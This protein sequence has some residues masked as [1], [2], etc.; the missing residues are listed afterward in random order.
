MA[1]ARTYPMAIKPVH[2]MTLLSLGLQLGASVALA[3]PVMPAEAHAEPELG[4]AVTPSAQAISYVFWNLRQRQSLLQGDYSPEE[5]SPTDAWGEAELDYS[6]MDRAT[7]AAASAPAI[8][9]SEDDTRMYWGLSNFP[10]VSEDN[11]EDA[12]DLD[13]P[14]AIDRSYI[15]R[16]EQAA[17]RAPMV[18]L[19]A[20]SLRALVG[21]QTHFPRSIDFDEE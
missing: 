2:P 4:A 5:A 3:G 19:G 18:V 11:W 1:N 16:A 17:A 10:S 7:H 12:D 13:E 6:N 20:D 9:V 15:A 14:V 21:I 8:E